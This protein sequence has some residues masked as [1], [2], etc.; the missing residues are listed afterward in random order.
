[1]LFRKNKE[2]LPAKIQLT[3]INSIITVVTALIYSLVTYENSFCPEFVQVLGILSTI[4]IVVMIIGVFFKEAS[5]VQIIPED[6]KEKNNASIFFKIFGLAIAS[7]LIIYFVGYIY[8]I[9]TFDIKTGFLES[10]D[11]MWNKWDS[12]HYLNLAQNGYSTDGENAKLIVFYPFYPLLIRIAAVMFKNYLV[13]GV[14]VSNLCLGV[15][16]YYLYKLVKIDFDEETAFRSVKYM[17]IYPFSFFFGIAYTESTFVALSIMALYYMRKNKWFLAGI[18]GFL[19]ALTKNQGIILVIPAAMEYVISN[20]VFDELRKKNLKNILKSFF[21]KGIYILMIPLGTLVY[22]MINEILFG[23]WNEFLVYQNKYFGNS[24]GNVF[25]NIKRITQSAI[26]PEDTFRLTYWIPF[27]LSFLLVI[28][29]IFYSIGR[30]RISYSAYMLV[31][32][33]I[34]FSP[35]FLLSGARYILSL[36]PIYISLSVLARRKE[37]DVILTYS[38]TLL[39]GFYT[40]AFLMGRV[41]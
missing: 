13:S 18:C 1:M 27:I 25:K 40:L 41:L 2:L 23:N 29:L 21:A 20:Q 24:F 12:I 15:G 26:S 28:F 11:S 7:R 5:I 4:S 22:F 33:L 16:C 36:A 17:L 32:L 3:C 37:V 6:I 8:G 19:A 9:Q 10:F 30:L 39:L 14:V 31:F 35:S 34:S 38:S